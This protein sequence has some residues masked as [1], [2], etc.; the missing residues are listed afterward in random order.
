MLRAEDVLLDNGQNLVVALYTG[1]RAINKMNIMTGRAY[2]F[3]VNALVKKFNFPFNQ[4]ITTASADYAKLDTESGFDF[5][6]LGDTATAGKKLGGGDDRMRISSSNPFALSHF[7]PIPL[8]PELRLYF[9]YTSSGDNMTPFTYEGQE[10]PDPTAGDPGWDVR[11]ADLDGNDIRN[12]PAWLQRLSWY[13]ENDYP[14][15]IGGYNESKTNK[16]RPA[17]LIKGRTYQLTPVIDARE[18]K[19]I[20]SGRKPRTFVQIGGIKKVSPSITPREW[21][22]VGCDIALEDVEQ[23]GG[24]RQ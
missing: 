5:D 6:Y 13:T 12:P 21:D 20:V 15:E 9:R 10:K 1:D 7:F 18:Q 17:I 3:K 2:T 24:G 14:F 16:I 23:I 8:N 4:F 11:G 22:Q 19:N